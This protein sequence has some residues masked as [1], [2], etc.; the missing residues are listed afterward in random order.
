[1]TYYLL[2]ARFTWDDVPLRLFGN[3]FWAHVEAQQ[4][5]AN[6]SLLETKWIDSLRVWPAGKGDHDLLGDFVGALVLKINK[7]S[8][9]P[10]EVTFFEGV[11][12]NQVES[13]QPAPA[14]ASL[15]SGYVEITDPNHKLRPGVDFYLSLNWSPGEWILITETDAVLISDWS[16][17]GY[18]F[19]CPA[20]HHPDL[21]G[22]S[23]PSIPV[24]V[25]ELD[26]LRDANAILRKEN[27]DLQAKILGLQI[28]VGS[29]R[30]ENSDLRR[31]NEDLNQRLKGTLARASQATDLE[32]RIRV[33]AIN[34]V[35][36]HAKLHERRIWS[37]VFAA[38]RQMPQAYTEALLT[39][40]G[41]FTDAFL[42]FLQSFPHVQ[43][44]MPDEWQIDFEAAADDD[45]DDGMAD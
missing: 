13:V 33:S 26:L 8:G 24:E 6:P 42:L 43:P 20:T 17:R 10:K 29:L 9:Y 15:P 2:I 14:E 7:L 19:C 34:L 28:E 45:D 36:F 35:K 23:S 18:R 16:E 3:P 39:V 4:L 30:A 38:E 40:E 37:S 41:A 44:D 22:V 32:A 21:Q 27:D 31:L 1:M 25:D 11:D 5:E 12:A